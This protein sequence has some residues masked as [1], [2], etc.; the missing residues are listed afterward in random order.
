MPNVNAP[1]GFKPAKEIGGQPW[2]GGMA[3]Y[4]LNSGYGTS[5]FEGDVVKLLSTGYLAK[6]AATEQMRGIVKGFKWV[7]VGGVP[8]FSPY[9]PAGTVTLGGV[10]AEVLVIDDPNCIFEVQMGGAATDWTVAMNGAIFELGDAG[11][12]TANGLSGEYLDITTLKTTAGQFRLLDVVP[13]PD[14][15]IRAGNAGYARVY[16]A[17]SLHDFR[18]NTGI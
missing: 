10:D 14:N 4:R 3:S 12:S 17:P 18:V 15:D 13:R 9:W 11:G 7:G 16:V 5:I 1:K 6:A 2:N 8:Q